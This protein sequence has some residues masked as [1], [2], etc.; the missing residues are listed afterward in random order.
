MGTIGNLTGSSVQYEVPRYLE[1]P[2]DRLGEGE[3]APMLLAVVR[4]QI[5]EEAVEGRLALLFDTSSL[6]N[7]KEA[8]HRLSAGL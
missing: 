3:P 5:Q 2:K 7:L 8:I 6:D 4:L 1:C